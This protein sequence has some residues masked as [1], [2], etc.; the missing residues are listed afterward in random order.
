MI[1]INL[2]P[3]VKQE[4]IHA[5]RVRTIVISSAILVGVI[6]VG[7]VVLMA[8]YLYGVQTVRSALADSDIKSK[9]ETL[10]KVDD[11]ENTLTIQHQLTR[12]NELH[13]QKSID[14]R[15]F[16][17][18]AAINPASPNNVSF[19]VARLD[20][21]EQIISLEGRANNGYN[22]A[23]VLKKT[24]LS[25]SLSYR[26]I[27]GTTQTAQLTDSVVTGDLSY[28]EDEEGKKVLNFSISFAYD[29]AFFD[30]G[31]QNAVI[32]RPDRQIVTDSFL[33][34]PDSLFGDSV[35]T[36]GEENG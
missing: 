1:E 10:S 14:S 24:I 21:V 23:E 2:I 36:E 33:R 17:L 8:V 34:L 19:S 16:D 3:D 9:Y 6:S 22:A 32:V 11:L 18:L 15:F 4:Y 7:I 27:D 25:T 26:D 31:S 12:L 13:D 30:R 35:I 28:G 29:P 5:K 20:S